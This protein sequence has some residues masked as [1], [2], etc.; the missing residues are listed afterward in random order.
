MILQPVILKV[1]ADIRATK[2]RPKVQALSQLARQA[3]Q[4]SARL[5]IG[6]DLKGFPKDSDGVPVPVKGI[7]WSLSHKSSLVAG[8]VAK[9]PVGID[10]EIHRP[11]KAGMHTRIAGDD[12]WALALQEGDG[13]VPPEP[14]FYRLWTAKEAVLKA[15]GQGLVGLSRCRV[16]ALPADLHMRLSYDGTPWEVLQRWYGAHLVALAFPAAALP[17]G[18]VIW[19]QGDLPEAQL[20]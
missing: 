20:P 16:D 1:P 11:V 17:P 15:V 2:G 13:G 6:R 9:V 19:P 8:I 12:E 18:G 14:L 5:T 10:V 4:Q 7:H 3:T